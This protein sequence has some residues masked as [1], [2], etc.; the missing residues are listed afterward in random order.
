MAAEIKI[1]SDST[2]IVNFPSWPI[3]AIPLQAGTGKFD[4][5]TTLPVGIP[6]GGVYGTQSPLPAGLHL[7]TAG[8]LNADA[9]TPAGTISGVVFTYTLPTA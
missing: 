3:P 1:I 4:L 9:G 7:T 2:T 8:V 6:S 5:S